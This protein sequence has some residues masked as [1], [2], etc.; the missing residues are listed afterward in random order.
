MEKKIRLSDNPNFG[1][2]VYAIVI[3]ALC[4]AAIIIGIVAAS[5][6][7]GPALENPPDSSQ[8]EP[9]GEEPNDNPPEEQP[10][11]E[12]P[13][14]KPEKATFIS[15]VSGTLLKPHSMTVPV[16]SAT[17]EAW[18]LHTGIDISTDDSADVFSAFDGTVCEVFADAMLGMT[19][20]VDHG[21][22]VKTYYSNLDPNADTVK[23]GAVLKAGD[24]IGCVGDSSIAELADEAHLHFEVKVD[25]VSVDPLE[26]ISEEAKSVSLGITSEN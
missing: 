25:E 11:E 2:T 6:D 22:N 26:Y 9:S 20:V 13:Q 19:V 8:N 17:L 15:P 14:R 5:R 7:E 3:A 10:P 24:R 4:I 18:K 21:S 16:F 12:E 1:K 23:V